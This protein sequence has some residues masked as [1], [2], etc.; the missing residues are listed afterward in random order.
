MPLD[1]I[2]SADGLGSPMMG[3]I[4]PCIVTRAL[5]ILHGGC[6]VTTMC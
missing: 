5:S 6:I 1:M 3:Q 4:M 2:M